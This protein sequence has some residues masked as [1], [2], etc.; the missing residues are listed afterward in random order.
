MLSLIPGNTKILIIILLI[1][2]LGLVFIIIS[3]LFSKKELRTSPLP[4]SV[5]SFSPAPSSEITQPPITYESPKTKKLLDR[6]ENRQTLSSLDQAAKDSLLSSIGNQSSIL[7]T[8]STFKVEY[9]KA[10]DEFMVEILT[11]DIDLAKEETVSWFKEQGFSD[12]GI[13]QVPAVFYLNFE[14]S[15]K[16][17]GSGYKFDPM[18]PG[19]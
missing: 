6:L 15:N 18:A 9:V 14:V 4:S 1:A 16:L 2:I 17:R 10:A 8:T 11:T 12:E 3:S 13:C 7:I 5:P 19:C